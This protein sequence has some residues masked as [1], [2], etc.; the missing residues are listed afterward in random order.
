MANEIVFIVDTKNPE[1]E[2]NKKP[3]YYIKHDGPKTGKRASQGFRNKADAE[4]YYRSCEVRSLSPAAS[5]MF[6][7]FTLKF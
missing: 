3:Y 2:Q 5:V 1:T 7:A 6:F 4:R